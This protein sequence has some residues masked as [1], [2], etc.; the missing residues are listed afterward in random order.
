MKTKTLILASALTIG[1]AASAHTV[2]D[3]TST[4]YTIDTKTSKVVWTATKIGGSHT[5]GIDIAR[6]SLTTK[7]NNASTAN[8]VMDMKSIHNTDL[9]DASYKAKL[10][11]HLKSDD[12]FAVEKFAESSFNVSGFSPIENAK[13]G[14]ANYTIKGDLT[15]KGITHAIS[16]PGIVKISGT[17]AVV[18]GKLTFDRSKWDVKYGSG[19][20]FEGLGDHLIHDDVELKFE[21]HA[22]TL[23]LN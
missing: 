13:N 5:G 22:S 15:I 11:G 16:F 6:G 8:I 9:E 2:G 4:K 10:E 20:F 19:S 23:S 7:N 12:F 1:T 17:E 21:L 14:A 3:E 18:T